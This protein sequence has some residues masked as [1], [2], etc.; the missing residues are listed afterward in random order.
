MSF[1]S[2]LDQI[3]IDFKDFFKVALPIAVDAEPVIAILFPQFSGLYDEAVRLIQMAEAAASAS[4]AQKAGKQKLAFVIVGLHHYAVRNQI[5]LR[6]APPTIQQTQDYAQ[7]V[8]NG[9][10]SYGALPKI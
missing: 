4:G 9:M 8:V 1:T 10:K 7:S 6:I 3:G 2:V 5:T